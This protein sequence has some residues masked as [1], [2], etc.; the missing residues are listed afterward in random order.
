MLIV[1]NLIVELSV[2]YIVCE[3]HPFCLKMFALR[4]GNLQVIKTSSSAWFSWVAISLCP[5]CSDV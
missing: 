3:S 4:M 5:R 1:L 2:Y